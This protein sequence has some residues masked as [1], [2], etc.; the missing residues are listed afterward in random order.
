MP[1]LM[2]RRYS[3]A[4]YGSRH[5]TTLSASSGGLK[6]R[7]VQVTEHCENW[8]PFDCSSNASGWWKHAL[9]ATEAAIVATNIP[10]A[11]Q[12]IG[13]RPLRLEERLR[14]A[15]LLAVGTAQTSVDPDR[16]PTHRDGQRCRSLDALA[17]PGAAAMLLLPCFHAP[18]ERNTAP[19]ASWRASRALHDL[20]PTP[21]IATLSPP[22]PA[23]TSPKGPLQL[24]RRYA[25]AH[26]FSSIR[27]WEYNPLHGL[28]QLWIM[29]RPRAT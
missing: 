6:A 9:R 23:C 11:F 26:H 22:M 15:L 18:G 4:P 17:P 8:T 14:G 1:S 5:I 24:Y 13:R 21:T 2:V 12:V 29:R 19:S 10:L 7:C 28:A 3:G 20:P 25:P 16:G 27:R